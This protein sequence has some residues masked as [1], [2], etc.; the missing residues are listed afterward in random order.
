MIRRLLLA[1]VAVVAVTTASAVPAN[2]ACAPVDSKKFW[3]HRVCMAV[4]DTTIEAPYLAQQINI[5]GGMQ[6]Q[7][8]NNCV[9]L[10]YTP[11][12]RFTID[13]YYDS[14]GPCWTVLGPNGGIVQV[15]SPTNGAGPWWNYVNNP[16]LW[17][18]E[19]CLPGHPG[20]TQARHNVS[21]AIVNLLGVGVTNS[22]GWNS[23]I[24]NMT[25]WSQL[26]VPVADSNTG[27]LLE[28]IYNGDCG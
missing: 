21:A 18:N 15:D 16:V 2:A 4:G 9:S 14:S 6:I 8:A 5:K 17:V 10:G 23:R 24:H 27:D 12:R 26:N 7:A 20:S 1:V 28:S 19:R 13:L 3:T 25:A 11:S 22:S